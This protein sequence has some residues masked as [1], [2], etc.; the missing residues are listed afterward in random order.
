VAVALITPGPVVITV[1]FIGYLVAGITGAISAA[2]GVFAPVY[3]LTI[4]LAPQYHRF[5][6]DPRVRAF[7]DGVTAAATGAIAGAAVVLGRRALVDV[8]TIA[9]AIVALLLVSR[10]R[11]LPEPLVML[12]AG[13]VGVVA[14]GAN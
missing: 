5:K 9:I 12:A 13:L 10:A 3:L 11:R 7:I 6:S 14:R 8:T 4:V 2:A 1:A